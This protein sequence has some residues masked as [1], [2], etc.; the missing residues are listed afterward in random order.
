LAFQKLFGFVGQSSLGVTKKYCAWW[1]YKSSSPQKGDMVTKCNQ[2][3][4]LV[5]VSSPRWLVIEWEAM[6]WS[7]IR[8]GLD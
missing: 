2:P 6:A 1:G 3:M 8:G 4:Y 5:L 7:C